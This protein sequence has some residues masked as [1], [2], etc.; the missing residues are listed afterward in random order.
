MLKPL[1]LSKS[2]SVFLSDVLELF[3]PFSMLLRDASGISSL[4]TLF[5]SSWL[6]L[7]ELFPPFSLLL[8]DAGG[9][10]LLSTIFASSWLLLVKLQSAKS[11]AK[12]S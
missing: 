4:S 6:F 9:I 7:V 8:R 12:K 5:A 10:S 1:T 2:F 11:E 3:P